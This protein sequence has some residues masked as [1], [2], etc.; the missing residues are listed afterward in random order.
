M[1][2]TQMTVAP[3][4]AI[5]DAT[6]AAPSANCL[7]LGSATA[8]NYCVREGGP[9]DEG[10]IREFAAGLSE[11]T[12]YLRFF[13]PIPAASPSVL[14]VLTG[15]IPGSDIL[16]ITDQQGA[17]IGHGM[18]ADIT[19]DGRPAVDLGLVIAD[20]WQ[21]QGLGTVLLGLLAQRAASRGARALAVEVLP[22]NSR[23]LA[24]LRRHWPNAR[25]TWTGEAF[26]LRA[27]I[28]DLLWPA[29]AAATS[30]AGRQA[31]AAAA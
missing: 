12:R 13:S 15:G 8:G 1:N 16:V 27:D 20:A 6:A 22:G 30:R 4:A 3:T 10:G 23:M 2:G 31:L 9:G 21:G 5:N 11:P 25:R 14:R 18:A 24:L 29:A 19:A 17:V 26:A 28:A 7:A